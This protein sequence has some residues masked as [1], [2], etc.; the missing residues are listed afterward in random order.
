MTQKQ[1]FEDKGSPEGKGGQ[2]GD[3]PKGGEGSGK[4]AM[5]NPNRMAMGAG[6]MRGRRRWQQVVRERGVLESRELVAKALGGL[7]W[8]SVEAVEMN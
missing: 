3:R 6:Q 1:L 5:G 2:G 7:V 8:E 4:C